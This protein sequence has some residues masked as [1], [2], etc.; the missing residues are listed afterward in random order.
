[1]KNMA[2]GPW[3]RKSAGDV[4]M[5][6]AR[7]DKL[8]VSELDDEVL[9]YDLNSHKAHSLNRTT[10]LVW[11][12]CDGQTTVGAVAGLLQRELQAPV[13]EDVVWMAL[14][15][16]NR[17]TLLQ[18]PLSPSTDARRY[19][20]QEVL[21]KAGIAAVALPVLASIVAPTAASAASCAASS[22][23]S[24]GCPCQTSSQ[25]ASGSNGPCCKNGVCGNAN[26]GCS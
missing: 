3:D 18:E 15:Q 9:V 1:M 22:G 17:A 5:P 10:A 26:S 19:S 11:R 12:H 24:I 25:C 21:R 4:R 6:R 23:R 7:V 2:E 16:L 20:R 14:H 8:V 13:D